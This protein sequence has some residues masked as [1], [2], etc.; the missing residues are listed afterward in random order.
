[1]AR[2][3]A[4]RGDGRRSRPARAGSARARSQ[5][6]TWAGSPTTSRRTCTRTAG[7]WPAA[8]E[9]EPANAL[10]GFQVHGADV[11]RHGA[12]PRACRTCARRTTH[13]RRTATRPRSTASRRSSSSRTACRSRSR[14]RRGRDAP[15][16]LARP[17]RGDRRARASGRSAPRRRPS[18]RGSARAASRSARRSWREFA[19][20]GDGIADG[21]ML[22]LPEVTERLLRAAGVEADRAR[23]PL[24]ELR[25][26]ALLLAPPRRRR[27]R[28]SGRDGVANGR[29]DHRHRSRASSAANLERV[30]AEAG[31]GVRVLVATK[32]VPT[33]SCRR[34]PRRESTSSARTGCRTS[35]ESRRWSETCSSGT[36]SAGSR[37]AR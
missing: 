18:D 22:D 25:A 32:Y 4:A 11:L 1:M 8:A 20:L 15:L 14:P 17:G 37:A 7:T 10:T 26:R 19:H 36:S 13:R 24:H 9:F 31:E 21:R 12:A 5:A 35:S 23:G 16:R 30:R 34:W 29:A 33:T 27:H 28:T 6:S 2:S 3:R